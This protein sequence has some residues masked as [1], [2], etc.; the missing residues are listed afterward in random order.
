[1]DGSKFSLWYLSPR[2]FRVFLKQKTLNRHKAEKMVR[3]AFPNVTYSENKFVNVKRD[4]SPFDGDINYWSNRNSKHYDRTTAKTLRTQNHSCG[5]CGLKFLDEEKVE[6]HHIDG[7]HNNWDSKNLLAIHTKGLPAC[8]C[9]H[10]V[11][12]GKGRKD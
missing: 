9:H 12:M 3:L 2:T 6:L 4:K 5:H 10:Y 1:M 7:N 8:S 11:H